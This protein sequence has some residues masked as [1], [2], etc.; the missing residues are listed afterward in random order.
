MIEIEATSPSEN[1]HLVASSLP[2][3]GTVT[4]ADLGHALRAGAFDFRTAPRFGVFFSAVYVL[5]GFLMVWLGAGTVVW[6]LAVSLGFP[7]VPPF[8]AA[9]LYEVSRRLEQGERLTW[10]GVLGV[11]WRE[12]TRQLPWAGAIIVIYFLFY[13]FLAHMIFALFMGLSPMTNVSSG[14][15]AFLT[16]QGLTVVAVEFAVGGV[17]AFL[18]YALT[19][20]SL[21]LLLDRELDF[22]SAMILSFNVVAQNPVTM[23]A[24]ALLIAVTTLLALVPWFLGLVVVL[25]VL[26]HATWHLYRRALS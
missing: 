16:R 12:R 25:P 23:G 22:V 7:L 9:G 18:L 3:I 15:D 13:T 11:V 14:W 26:G 20:V 8:A 2:D 1:A 19:V 21:P 4:F 5:G 10:E 17:L 6:T 24:W